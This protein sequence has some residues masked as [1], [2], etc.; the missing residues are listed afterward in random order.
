LAASLDKV[1]LVRRGKEEQR[2]MLFA[3][4]GH[5]GPRGQELRPKVR[6]SHL[7]YVRAAAQKGKIVLGGRFTDGSGSL[8]VL[9]AESQEEALKFAQSD[10]YTKEGVFERVDVKPFQKVF[11]E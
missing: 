7:E 8:I 10:P 9:D 4:I 5:D 2:G 1:F 6:P 3:L 11:P